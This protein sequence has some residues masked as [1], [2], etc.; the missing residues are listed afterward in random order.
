MHQFD[1]TRY[2]CDRAATVAAYQRTP[3]G[4]SGTC[5]CNGCRNFAAARIRALPPRFLELLDALGIDASKDAE[6][7]HCARHRPGFHYYGG[8]Y[9]FVGHLTVDGDFAA[10]D[11]GNGF[12]ASLCKAT[13]PRL[14][15]LEGLPVVQLE[16]H[17]ESVPWVLPEPEPI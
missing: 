13:A 10:V 4:G 2:T 5:R 6:V 12:T 9:H 1:K 3:A 7:F 17:S 16:F 14:K 8:W 11:F 15:S